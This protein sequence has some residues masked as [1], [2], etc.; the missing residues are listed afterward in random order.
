MKK[1][2]KVVG[3]VSVTAIAGV[4]VLGAVAFAQRPAGGPFGPGGKM[5]RP[6]FGMRGPGA[7]GPMGHPGGPMGGEVLAEAL[8]MSVEDFQTALAEGQ[9]PQEIAQAQGVD[10]SDVEAAMQAEA[11]EHLQQAVDD[12][13][14]TQEQA[15]A[16]LERMAEHPFDGGAFMKRP[17]GFNS[18]QFG[19]AG[20]PGG[21]EMDRGNEL[22]EVLGMSQEEFRAALEEGQQQVLV[23]IVESQGMTLEEVAQA[24]YDKAVERLESAVAD[25]KL[26][27][28]Q[29]DRIL[30]KVTERRDA[31]VN[32][33]DCT[34]T[35]PRPPRPPMTR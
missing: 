4:L 12:G 10:W 22:A 20:R 2:I 21:P 26:T 23:D 9:T 1:W 11:E 15:D 6:P 8:G 7:S 34:L 27:Q 3:I 35:P 31:C 28:E 14:L 17:G 32:D 13:K 18:R 19:P 30:E 5:G 24:L 25:G 16:I 29:A 33:G